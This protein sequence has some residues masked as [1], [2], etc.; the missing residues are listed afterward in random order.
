MVKRSCAQSQRAPRRRS[1]RVIAPP[2][3]AFHSQ[4]CSRK[5]SRPMSARLTPWLSRLRSTTIWVAMPAWS[6]PT[7]HSASLPCIRSRRV[8]TSCSV[9]V[10]R[11]A[12][13]QR[14]GDVG[15]RHDDRPRLASGRV[16]AE[17]ALRLPNARTSD[18]RSR[19]VRR[20]W[21]A[22]S[23]RSA[24][25]DAALQHQP[26]SGLACAAGA[27]AVQRP[28]PA[29]PAVAAS[30]TPRH[31]I[32]SSSSASAPSGSRRGRSAAATGCRGAGAR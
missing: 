21:E 14:A 12:D 19:G 4:T 16:G 28:R 6:V 8:R 1:W 15:R 13:V 25:S 7:T 17:Q 24:V 20:S 22:R 3:C 26:R 2:D 30:R 10:E 27:G 29:Q 5:A 11:V 31:T 9:I 23:C 32:G 18:P